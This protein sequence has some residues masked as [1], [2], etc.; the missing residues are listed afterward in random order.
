MMSV[1]ATCAKMK[2]KPRIFPKLAAELDK[3][4]WL[5]LLEPSKASGMSIVYLCII[6]FSETD[7]F[8]CTGL[9]AFER[10]FDSSYDKCDK[11]SRYRVE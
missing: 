11:Q 1:I 9:P 8:L 7:V 5:L 10:T 2:H 6:M 4:S 3:V